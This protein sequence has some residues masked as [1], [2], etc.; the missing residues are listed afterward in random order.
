V[1]LLDLKLAENGCRCTYDLQKSEVSGE[2]VVKRDV[3]NDPGV[4]VA[5]CQRPAFAPIVDDCV[6]QRVAQH[7]DATA[8]LPAEQIDTHDAEDEPEDKAD[9]QHVEDGWNRLDQRV[10]DH[11]EPHLI[12]TVPVCYLLQ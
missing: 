11:L 1:K 2:D 5:I 7:V 12:C 6:R 4:V 10:H 8:V 3:W 9:Q